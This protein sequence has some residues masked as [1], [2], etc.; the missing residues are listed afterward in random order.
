M[1]LIPPISHEI[2]CNIF[3]LCYLNLLVAVEV[4][5]LVTEYL[6]KK[7]LHLINI[8]VYA[9]AMA[10]MWKSDNCGDPSLLPPLGFELSLSG[11]VAS[12]FTH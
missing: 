7:L 12:A 9:C 3:L 2:H 10:H 1:I 4:T 5:C 11:L 8:C 6:L